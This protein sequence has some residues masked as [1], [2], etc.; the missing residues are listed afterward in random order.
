MADVVYSTH[1]CLSAESGATS[2]D[3]KEDVLDGL[4]D[5]WYPI[6]GNSLP[7]LVQFYDSLNRPQPEIPCTL[8]VG[9]SKYAQ[10]SDKNGEVLFWVREENAGEN[11]LCNAYPDHPVEAY[12]LVFV[13]E[14]TQMDMFM[15]KKAYFLTGAGML[16]LRD[17][18]IRVLYPEGYEEK[19]SHMLA[20]FTKEKKII[21][22]AIGIKLL[23]FKAI[24][25][26]SSS[27]GISV[28]GYGLP[29]TLGG[30][31]TDVE[32]YVYFPHEWIE[33]SL[34]HYY[35]IYDDTI[36]L[37][38]WIGDGLA[39]YV[40]F[41]ICKQLYPLYHQQLGIGMYEY[42]ESEQ[43]H[44]L[45]NR[46][47]VGYKRYDLAPYFWAKVVD[48][49]GNPEIIPEFLEGF[50]KSEDHTSQNAIALLTRLSGLDIDK[51]LV[52]AGQE[53]AENVV[54]YWPIPVPPSGMNLIFAGNPFL[55]GDSSEKSTSTVRNVQL[56]SFFLDRYEVTNEQ[57]CEFLN[58]MGNQKEGGSYW[59]DE[60][61]YP[62]ILLEDGKYI[63]RKGRDNYPVGQVS[64]YGAAAY[65]KWAGKRLPTEAEWEFAASNN[66]T[67]LYPW[68]GEWHDDY[69][70]WGEEGKLDG[71]EFTAPVDA[72][73]QSKN[74][75]D[76]YNMVGNVFEWVAD[77][78]APYNPADT[79]NPQGPADGE[80]KVHRGGC[81]K[82]SKEWQTSKTRIGGPPDACYS[83]VGFRCAADVPK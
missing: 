46:S 61:S 28:G 21:E 12:Y 52:I 15:S 57:F 14:G 19:A 79:L 62:D 77:W 18:G 60:T 10:I 74:H 30:N 35:H 37:C 17:G 64:W 20:I 75:Y 41:E 65:A 69:C 51:E 33:S 81:Y 47:A 43:I 63:V 76:C 78:Y 22:S 32:T 13:S 42:R 11:I 68:N 70:N 50:R 29:L 73:E 3:V 45:L 25:R 82:Y 58:A 67:T 55:M 23:P 6:K 27:S 36:N 4:L 53:Y 31:Y 38:R 54:R 2:V 59:L 72:F 71:Y 5:T 40:A 24:L 44:D 1:A 83:C 7:V 8:T 80:N 56:E 34:R 26:D 48:K 16:E 39:N 49:S 9:S 66:G